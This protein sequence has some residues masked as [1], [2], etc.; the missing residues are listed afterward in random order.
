MSKF[1]NKNRPNSSK[2][3]KTILLNKEFQSKVRRARQTAN[4]RQVMC[5]LPLQ[6]QSFVPKNVKFHKNWNVFLLSATF[7]GTNGGVGIRRHIIY[8]QYGWAI[9]KKS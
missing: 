9:V 1:L 2:V 3:T 5:V 6:K 7:F 8:C 4:N